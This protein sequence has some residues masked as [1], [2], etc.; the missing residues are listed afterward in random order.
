M[1]LLLIEDLLRVD[2]FNDLEL[3]ALHFNFLATLVL[4]QVGLC[5]Q[6]KILLCYH[7]FFPIPSNYIKALSP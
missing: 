1:Y 4:K 5:F 7:Y 3:Q 6:L 2:L